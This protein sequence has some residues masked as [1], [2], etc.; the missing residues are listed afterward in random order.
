MQSAKKPVRPRNAQTEGGI[1]SSFTRSRDSVSPE[2][3]H[4]GLKRRVVLFSALLLVL[5]GVVTWRFAFEA[6]VRVIEYQAVTLA[7]VVARQAASARL[8]YTQ[9]VVE[10]L[11]RDGF[12]SHP[13][14][15]DKRG[16]V[17]LPAQF[18]KML[19]KSATAESAGLYR[20][21]PLSKWNLA[22]DQ[23]L[24]D[25]FQRWAWQE[26]ESQDHLDPEKP[27]SWIPR[28]RIEDLNGVRTL[29]YM[30]ADPA[31]S[32]ACVSCHNE[33]ELRPDIV[34][35]RSSD[36]IETGKQWRQHQLLGAIEVNIPLDKVEALARGETHQTIT[37]IVGVVVGGLLIIGFFVFTDVTRARSMALQLAWHAKHDPL[38]GMANRGEFEWVL[39]RLLTL[40]RTDDSEHALLFMDLDQFKI[41]NDTSGHMVGD[42]LLRQ[43]GTTLKSHIRAND[44]L[45]R[46]GGDE[47]GVLLERCSLGHAR[48]IAEKLCRAVGD[49]RFVWDGRTFEI[50]ASIGLVMI[51]RD[52]ESA[53]ALMSAADVACY[54]AKDAGRHRVHVFTSSDAE[55]GQRRTEMEWASRITRALN[56]NWFR[57]DVQQGIALRDD[58]AFQKYTE[59][60]LRMDDDQGGSV[61]IYTV[62]N[63]AER[64]DLMPA[65]D[66]WVLRNICQYLATGALRLDKRSLIAI[67]ISGMS[68]NDETFLDYAH[69]QLNACGKNAS[70]ICFEI[71]E[72]AAIRNFS[73][74]NEF[75]EAL[76]GLG[77]HF[78]LDDFGS[79]LSSF[80]YLKN[81]PVNFLKLDGNFVRDIESD[82]IDRTMVQ[83]IAQIGRVMGIPIIA[84]SVENDAILELVRSFGIDYAQGF[85]VNKPR[86][87]EDIL[88]Q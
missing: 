47:F 74:A 39:D 83:T 4:A 85:G 81:L 79:G 21:R 52:S 38:T 11:R 2:H 71:T 56:E 37:V 65:V 3:L 62:I 49:F 69:S 26:L 16:F 13:D 66:R 36:G 63:A 55:I 10:K 6:Q 78:A 28:W 41:I 40:A 22:E 5:V 73:K 87:I 1:A 72:T 64:Y 46:L 60:L 7:E 33:Y 30:R 51:N 35:R 67:N 59:V 53:A 9:N 86:P 20:Y 42:E 32:Q 34:A 75:I 70:R 43:I 80:G 31:V 24:T 58:A 54:A 84:E 77:C 18:L 57:L 68:V 27:I 88:R 25:D 61:P 17:A 50:G 44:T 45:A 76:R 14:Y 12:G 23:G 82:M 29:R 19:G 15:S 8:V 48:D